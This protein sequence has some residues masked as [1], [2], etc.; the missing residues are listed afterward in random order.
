[1]PIRVCLVQAS[2]QHVVR[3]EPQSLGI[4]QHGTPMHERQIRVVAGFDVIGACRR[5]PHLHARVRRG[6][7]VERACRHSLGS[8]VDQHRVV[9]RGRAE[10]IPNVGG[11]GVGRRSRVDQQRPVRHRKHQRQRVGMRVTAKAVVV[12][13]QGRTIRFDVSAFDER[14]RIGE[15]THERVIVNVA[16][17]DQRV[18]RKLTV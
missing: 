12:E 10:A 13:V 8:T 9:H 16:K 15:G 18:Q 2:A 17:F 1:M 4:H 3:D 5:T 14:E 11:R 6:L 7:P